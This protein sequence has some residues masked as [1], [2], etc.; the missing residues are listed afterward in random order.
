MN[1]NLEILKNNRRKILLSLTIA[2]VPVLLLKEVLF[3]P[4]YPWGADGL[5]NLLPPLHARWSLVQGKLPI[6]TELWYG[7]E[8]QPFNPLWKG[9]YPPAWPLFIPGIPILLATRGVLAIHYMAA[10]V[11]AF[12]YLSEDFDDRVAIPFALL[13]LSPMA[14]FLGHYE[15]V[16][17][18]PWA[19]LLMCQ[20]VP[21]RL[22]DAPHRRGVIAGVSLAAMLLAG[23]N[24]HFFFI[25]LVFMAVILGTKEWQALLGGIK[26]GLVAAPKILFSILPVILLGPDRPTGGRGLNLQQFVTGVTGF[27]VDLSGLEIVFQK[28]IFF[29]G[30]VAVGLPAVLLAGAYLLYVYLSGWELGWTSSLAAVAVFGVLVITQWTWLDHLPVL[31]MFRVTARANVITAVVVLLLAWTAVYRVH[32]SGMS[33]L[34]EYVPQ[35]ITQRHLSIVVVGLVVLSAANGVG[36]WSVVEDKRAIQTTQGETIATEIVESDCDTVWLE[37]R[38]NQTR[39]PYHKP[40]AFELTKR[41][42]PLTAV[43]YG[44][45]GQEYNAINDGEITFDVLLI[46]APLPSNGTVDLTG[47]WGAPSRGQVPVNSLQLSNRIDTDRGPI[48]KYTVGGTC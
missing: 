16:L 32:E 44:Q 10:P 18:W 26:G 31:D 14:L 33:G 22:R 38:Y 28:A 8:Y 41:Q 36:A 17:G 4:G 45:I 47:G 40:I 2:A 46:G 6:Y 39:L 23:D 21:H 1:L 3:Q 35:R 25:W 12:W 34:P 37:G 9:F 42:I 7:G 19:V 48:Y 30:Y 43:N 11:I 20:L 27:W 24:Y 15:K 13:F 5:S 29:E